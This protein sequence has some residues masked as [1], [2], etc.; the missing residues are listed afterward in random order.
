MAKYSTH[1]VTVVHVNYFGS[2]RAFLLT[3]FDSEVHAQYH[4]VVKV[5]ILRAS[6]YENLSRFFIIHSFNLQVNLP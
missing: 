6:K 4:L 1:F 5:R 2:E 3:F